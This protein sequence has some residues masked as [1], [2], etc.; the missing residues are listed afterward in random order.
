MHPPVNNC[1]SSGTDMD[2]PKLVS[3]QALALFATKINISK[4][5]WVIYLIREHIEVKLKRDKNVLTYLESQ[6]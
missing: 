3:I 1:Y 4:T 6:S 5:E 2:M